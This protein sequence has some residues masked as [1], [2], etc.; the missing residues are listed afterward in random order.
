MQSARRVI[1]VE[2]CSDAVKDAKI[3]AS[4]NGEHLCWHLAVISNLLLHGVS[5]KGPVFPCTG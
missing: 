3:N 1:G 4:I 2:L 5:D